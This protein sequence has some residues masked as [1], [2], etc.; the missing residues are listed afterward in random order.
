[1]TA[2]LGMFRLVF[3]DSAIDRSRC[4]RRAGVLRLLKVLGPPDGCGLSA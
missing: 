3:I 1:M 2:V 4:H